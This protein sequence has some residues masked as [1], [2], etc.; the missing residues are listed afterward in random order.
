LDKISSYR[1]RREFM[2]TTKFLIIFSLFTIML[3]GGFAF[4]YLKGLEP[5]KNIKIESVKKEETEKNKE[6]SIQ[7][8]ISYDDKDGVDKLDE[9]LPKEMSKANDN[10]LKKFIVKKY[11]DWEV[12][13]IK[14]LSE[15][16][17]V[18]HTLGKV[19]SSYNEEDKNNIEDKNNVEDRTFKYKVGIEKDE[20]VIFKL[21]SDGKE[22][23]YKHTHRYIDS[24]RKEDK[25]IFI[26]GKVFDTEEE[27]TN[28]IENYIS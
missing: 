10:E 9:I 3:M 21:Y 13:E 18:V 14:S 28:F 6:I 8:I 24:I 2:K 1:V 25:D 22:E 5:E 27:M 7:Y 20:I 12:N 16:M 11:P 26:N 15:D 19:S 23:L 4:G 17:I